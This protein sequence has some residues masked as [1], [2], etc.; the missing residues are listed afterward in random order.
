MVRRKPG[1]GFCGAAEP[2]LVKVPEGRTY[3]DEADPCMMSCGDQGCR[4]WANLEV[5]GGPHAGEF[6]FHISE[7]QMDDVR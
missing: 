5:V 2:A 7:C 1:S 3:I 4:E 6:M